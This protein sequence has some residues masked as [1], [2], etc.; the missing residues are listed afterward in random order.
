MLLLSLLL[1]AVRLCS[2]PAH[3]RLIYSHSLLNATPAAGESIVN[4]GGGFV[5]GKG[6]QATTENSQLRI[7]LASAL[8]FEGTFIINVTNFDPVSQNLP[9]DIKQ[10]IINLYSRIYDNNKD[11]FET[12]GSWCNIRT[13]VGYSTGEGVAG[14]KFL[15]A[16]RG[17]DTRDEERCI[18]DHTWSLT[19]TYEFKIIWTATY[20]Y[21]Y[22]DGSLMSR[23]PFA[24]QI[25]PFRYLLIGRD[26]LIWGYGAQPGV[27]FSNVRIYGPQSSPVQLS[28]RLLLQGAYEVGSHAMRTPAA[29]A[30]VP[31]QSPFPQAP[32]AA[33]TVPA[34]IVDWVL[35]GLRSTPTGA[36]VVQS[37]LWL[38][39]DGRLIDPATAGT[40]VTLAAVTGSY[41]VTVQ[42]RNHLAA[43][44]ATALVFDGLNESNC[45]F[46]TGTASYYGGKGAV[47]MEAG[48]WALQAG[49]ING[50]KAVTAADF[51]LWQSAARTGTAGYAAADLNLDGC[52]TT[53]DYVLWFENARASA[54]SG[55]P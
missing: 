46:T 28:G 35:V 41:Y 20:I 48:V 49:D 21:C 30:A 50:D 38:R 51:S 8:P 6:W 40:T 27:I 23:L 11:I 34:G 55:M 9:D 22:L 7:T 5:A 42:T 47:Q 31:L 3:T 19:R 17:I 37:S 15:A 10:H 32:Y 52:C 18:E 4:S 1:P 53:R 45:D 33:S 43:M 26:N 44:S 29:G 36:P 39:S 2:Q 25:E 24:G 12:D 13:G 54:A 16:A 14:F